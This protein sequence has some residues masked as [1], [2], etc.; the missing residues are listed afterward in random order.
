MIVC[1]RPR[2]SCHWRW[3]EEEPSGERERNIAAVKLP[4]LTFALHKNLSRMIL[5]I[6][7]QQLRDI[8]R[9]RGG[10]HD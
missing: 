7:W 10:T 4:F 9:E 6:T 3:E 8:I 2:T 1:H 5:M